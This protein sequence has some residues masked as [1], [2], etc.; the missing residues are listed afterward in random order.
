MKDSA[1]TLNATPIRIAGSELAAPVVT[2]V[3]DKGRWRLEDAYTLEH[4]GHR[5]TIPAGFE[6]DLAS[7][8]RPLWWLIAPFELSIAAPL[9]HDFLYRYGGDP[10]E[11]S[12]TPSKTY[13]RKEA[14][15]LFRDVMRQEGVAAWRRTLAYLG[16]RWFGA[17]AWD[18]TSAKRL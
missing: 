8:P 18:A 14:D 15:G 10:P 11:G 9:V 4:N 3:D 13:T 5:I 16:S 12:V 1:R 17:F 6:F 2:Y 7:V